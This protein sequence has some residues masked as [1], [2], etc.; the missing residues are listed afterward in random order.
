M[1]TKVLLYHAQSCILP[2]ASLRLLGQLD[3]ACVLPT[4]KMGTISGNEVTL[5]TL[6]T[7][8]EKCSCLYK[9]K[10]VPAPSKLHQPKATSSKKLSETYTDPAQSFP[11]CEGE[12]GANQSFLILHS[13]C[14]DISMCPQW[15]HFKPS[16]KEAHVDLCVLLGFFAQSLTYLN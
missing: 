12:I 7:V 4:V 1:Q 10:C 5:L 14:T 13:S 15:Y 16:C 8:L 9:R 6:H 3:T 2:V 11:L